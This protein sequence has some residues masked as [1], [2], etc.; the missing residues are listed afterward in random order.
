ME[1]PTAPQRPTHSHDETSPSSQNY[2]SPL[3]RLPRELREL[4]YIHFIAIDQ[5]FRWD[6]QRV[7]YAER[8]PF[9]SSI[10]QINRQIREEAWD[11]LIRSN[12]WIRWSKPPTGGFH[13]YPQPCL[14][15]RQY[16][17]QYLDRIRNNVAVNFRLTRDTPAP[18]EHEIIFV[19]N[20][21][22]YGLFI[23]DISESHRVFSGLAV[24]VN[25][26]I[27][28]RR[29]LFTKLIE[30]LYSVRDHHDVTITG[31]GD[32]TACQALTHQMCRASNTIEE[33]VAVKECYQGLG[34]RAELDGRYSDAISSFALGIEA[35]YD[36]ADQFPQ[37]SPESNTLSHINSDSLIAY[38]R[39][40]Y[41]HIRWLKATAPLAELLE[42]AT[43]SL[44]LEAINA[45]SFAMAFVGVTD[46]QRCEA[47]LHRAFAFY[48]YAEY[49]SPFLDKASLDTL[50]QPPPSESPCR[51]THGDCYLHA[52]QNLF[53]AQQVDC[54]QDIL[55]GLDEV[56][57][58]V[59]DTI[60]GRPGPQAFKLKERK[61][62]L[63]GL[64]KGDTALWNGWPRQKSVLMA[65]FR[66][67]HNRG[68]DGKIGDP[69]DLRSAYRNHGI[70]WSYSD[71]QLVV[72]L[73]DID[74]S[75][76]LITI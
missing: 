38:S 23:H 37:G 39:N 49:Q 17:P 34:R 29:S 13:W 62:P 63:V 21:F 64:W 67:R 61:V 58:Q 74:D 19:Y 44:L 59:L 3:I 60:Q 50:D 46:H 75:S 73:F 66:Q 65:L 56:D 43:T 35:T 71:G 26:E 11:C 68:P 45:T 51:V 22:S 8:I 24:E 53:Y 2:I 9:D 1:V 4:V 10:L 76:L 20:P 72:N 54:W 42:T 18:E 48:H 57:L 31:L 70:A 5:H 27:S 15:E 12:I 69:M 32:L 52:T 16:P 33:V 40:I 36:T 14:L 25:P 7:W 47:H 30:P 55:A 6:S 41:K 28:Q